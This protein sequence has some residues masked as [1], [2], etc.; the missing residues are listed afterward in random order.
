MNGNV[1]NRGSVGRAATDDS[2]RVGCICR[3][4]TFP[5]PAESL[6]SLVDCWLV[7]GR[8]LV[9]HWYIAVKSP[10]HVPH[11]TYLTYLTHL[12]LVAALPR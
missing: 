6:R 5:A 2:C 10:V 8:L 11:L 7:A 12:T 9:G 4:F 3:A 1:S